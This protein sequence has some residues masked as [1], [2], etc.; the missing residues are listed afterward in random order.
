M[1]LSMIIIICMLFA[2][3][4]L[5]EIYKWV[6]EQGVTHYGDCPPTDCVYEEIELPKGPSE[7]EIEAAEERTREVLEARKAREAAE[8][9]RRE[10]ASLEEQEQEILRIERLQKCAE[11]IYQIDLLNQKRRVFKQQAGGSRLYLE[12]EERS[13]EITRI[14]AIKDQF[15]STDRSDQKEQLELAQEMSFALSRRCAAARETLAQMQQSSANP[16]EEK[17]ESYQA[18][19]EV[20]CPAIDSDDLWLGDWIIINKKR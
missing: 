1:R 19:V 4:T 9:T 16:I 5:A 12:N 11:A 7:E 17:L 18:Y 20:F 3:R 14:T 2:S 6:D 10:N 15:C 13:A 8:K